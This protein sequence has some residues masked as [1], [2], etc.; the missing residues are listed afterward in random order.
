MPVKSVRKS[1][2]FR[3]F[4][5]A[6]KLAKL[7]KKVPEDRKFS[8]IAY[9]KLD[10]LL[11][12]LGPSFS[13]TKSESLYEYLLAHKGTVS[14]AAHLHQVLVRRYTVPGKIDGVSVSVSATPHQWYDDGV[15]IVQGSG[16]FSGQLALYR[17][18]Q[19]L[20]GLAARTVAK[21]E[22]MGPS[23]ILFVPV[24]EAKKAAAKLG[25]TAREPESTRRL[26]D[27]ID[28]LATLLK[29]RDNAEGKYQSL[30]EDHPW[31]FGASHSK[32]T[33]K[34]KFDDEH[35][36]DFVARR[37]A[38][39]CFDIVEIKPPFLPLFSAD[40]TANA[41]FHEIW[42]QAEAYLHFARKNSAYLRDQKALEVR[43]P[44][45]FLVFMESHNVAVQKQLEIKTALNPA[46]RVYSW[47]D[48]LRL[49]TQTLALLKAVVADEAARAAPSADA[50]SLP[51]ESV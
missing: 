10:A 2:Q 20:F 34:V 37:V 27:G 4:K 26:Q 16:A 51:A 36:P 43:N 40:G 17:D 38:D 39:E 7:M 12:D 13:E 47:S 23:D 19:L 42:S 18:K 5:T 8:H 49:A 25:V 22:E 33:S 50:G 32:L 1:L 28:R 31:M 44:H 30:L 3:I 48:V 46:I 29:S 11:S 14:S 24:D 15:M 35:I 21:G 6:R 9:G 45:C 41:K